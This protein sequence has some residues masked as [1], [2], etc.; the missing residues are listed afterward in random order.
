VHLNQ[1]RESS[2]QVFICPVIN[3][4]L[5]C[6]IGWGCI[7]QLVNLTEVGIFTTHDPH[8]AEFYQELLYIAMTTQSWV[9][10]VTDPER[11]KLITKFTDFNEPIQVM[12]FNI[13]RQ[14]IYSIRSRMGKCSQ[15]KRSGKAWKNVPVQLSGLIQ[16]CCCSRDYMYVLMPMP[17]FL[18]SIC[19]TEKDPR[20]WQVLHTEIQ[21][22]RF[23]SGMGRISVEV[24]GNYAFLSGAYGKGFY[25]IDISDKTA[26]KSYIIPWKERIWHSSI[27]EWCLS[28]AR[29]WDI[30]FD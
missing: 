14:V 2:V 24:S 7:G 6:R 1:N 18:S 20:Y 21:H 26:P 27:W 16:W 25:I 3:I 30:G 11:P 8:D 13:W 19:M 17:D 22:Q 9:Y 28:G 12:T 10:N 4:H 15:Y 29:G 23:S 5:L